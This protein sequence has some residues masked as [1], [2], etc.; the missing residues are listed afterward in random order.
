MSLRKESKAI[1]TYAILGPVEI[2][3]RDY[4]LFYG[5]KLEEILSNPNARILITDQPG[6]GIYT[7]RY[8]KSQHYR[9]CIL[10]HVGDNPQHNIGMLNTRCG[11]ST[12]AESH[13]Q[14]ILDSDKVIDICG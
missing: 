10:Y 11:F 6:V 13:A 14:M 5:P 1:R 8:L 7:A 4:S 9:N 2:S 12:V 3:S